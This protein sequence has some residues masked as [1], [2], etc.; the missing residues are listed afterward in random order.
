MTVM[1]VREQVGTGVPLVELVVR[2]QD[3]TRPGWLHVQLEDVLRVQPRRLVVDVSA[4]ATL[5]AA[6]LRA[7]LDAHR[8]LRRRDAVLVLR[9]LSPRLLRVLSLNGLVDV[10]DIEGRARC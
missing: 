9:G 2:E 10:L 5:D 3:V 1:Q 6:T 4:C 7:L 8:R